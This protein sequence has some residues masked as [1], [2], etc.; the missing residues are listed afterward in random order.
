MNLGSEG[1]WFQFDEIGASVTGKIADFEEVQQTDMAT[2]E[3]AVWDDG[4]A[5]MALRVDLQ[6]ALRDDDADDGMRSVMI[7]GSKKPESGSSLAAVAGAIKASTGGNAI[8]V[9]ATLTLTYTGEKP[10]SRKGF[11]PAKVYSASYVPKSAAVN[12]P[13]EQA[14]KAM[15]AVETP[16]NVMTPEQMQALIA[17][18]TG[19]AS[20]PIAAHPQGAALRAAGVPD[21]VIKASLGLG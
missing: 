9:G 18:A 15:A 17:A 2:G 3:L 11:N 14:V 8:Q 12:A 20:D 4:R 5:K 19:K 13:V 6:T 16:G 7:R 1:S 10:A 21:D